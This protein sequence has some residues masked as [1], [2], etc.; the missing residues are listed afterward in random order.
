M[1]PKGLPKEAHTTLREGFN[2]VWKD[3]EYA[4]EYRRLTGQLS[5]PV[6]G[7]EIDAALKRIPK[8]P[9]VAEIYRRIAGP[10]PLPPVR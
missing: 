9:K 8:D 10:R 3:P 7:A 6:T 2:K 1:V 5:D 4:T